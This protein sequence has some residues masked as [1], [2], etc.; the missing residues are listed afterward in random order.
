MAEVTIQRCKV[1]VVRRGGWSWGPDPR[2]LAAF[3]VDRLPALIAAR[4][5]AID[6][7]GRDVAIATAVRLDVAISLRDLIEVAARNR[8]GETSEVGA[9]DVVGSRLIDA[10]E[11]SLRAHLTAVE[12]GP[13]SDS[14]REDHTPS[15]GRPGEGPPGEGLRDVLRRWQARGVLGLYLR[16]FSA[17]SLAAWHDALARRGGGPLDAEGGADARAMLETVRQVVALFGDTAPGPVEELRRRVAVAVESAAHR[18]VAP[19]DPRLWTAIDQIL[20]RPET[21]TGAAR[22]DPAVERDELADVRDGAAPAVDDQRTAGGS[23]LPDGRA[24]RPEGQEARAPLDRSALP[25]ARST[26]GESD[27]VQAGHSPAPRGEFR[28]ESALPFLLL[29]PLGQAGYLE[30][31]SASFDAAGLIDAMPVFAAAL[32]YK[33]LDPPERGWRRRASTIEAAAAFAGL[34]GEVAGAEVH[35]LARHAGVLLSPLDAVVA[36]ALIIGHRPGVPFLIRRLPDDTGGGWLLLDVEGHFPIAWSADLEGLDEP[37]N[38]VESEL[39][40]VPLDSADPRLLRQLDGRGRRFLTDARAS[41]GEPWRA[42]RR[43]ASRWWTNDASARPEGL[44]REAGRLVEA[45]ETA[46]ELWRTLAIERPAAPPASGDAL[47][48]SLALAAGLALGQ[49]AWT[50]WGDREPTDPLLALERLGSLDARVRLDDDAIRVT[51]PLGRRSLDLAGCGLLGDVA[52]VPW[53]GGRVVTFGK[54]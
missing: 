18:D 7:G 23:T 13:A 12:P 41:R 15:A 26:R 1:R 46:A 33:A 49:V 17:A 16:A 2:A 43:G 36:S 10:L 14:E 9:E 44:A 45:S 50:L 37:M 8:R 32:A 20:P 42:I 40:L 29:G 39:I 21:S 28:V 27:R 6:D 4:L 5:G 31:V 11:E 54:G 35:E 3:V 48:R 24:F 19:D 34:G 52:G 47:D 51:L 53:L 38:R 22:L 30:A 25:P